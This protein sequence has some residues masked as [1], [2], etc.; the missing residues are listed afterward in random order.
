MSVNWIMKR[1]RLSKLID[2]PGG[3]T[4]AAALKEAEVQT[5]EMRVEAMVVV[6]AGLDSLEAVLAAPPVEADLQAWLDRIYVLATRVSDAA[7]P[8]GLA[9]LC[10]AAFSL[11]ELAD[12]QKQARALDLPP[13]K[14]HMAA[15]R[16]LVGE[17][18]P[19][20]ARQAVLAGLAQV[21]E[22]TRRPA[23]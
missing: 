16:L 20:E 18:Q 3:T 2:A 17:G 12:R 1:S 11:C 22:K 5:R 8:F 7:G 19:P 23:V 15:L 10:A 21:V 4:V 14:V 6:A 13:L 9:D